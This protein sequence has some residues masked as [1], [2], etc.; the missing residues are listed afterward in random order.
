MMV[1][2]ARDILFSVNLSGFSSIPV[3]VSAQRPNSPDLSSP[4]T[5]EI[6]TAC[7]PPTIYV[8]RASCPRCPT[9][10]AREL[11]SWKEWANW[12]LAVAIARSRYGQRRALRSQRHRALRWHLHHQEI[13]Q[14]RPV[15]LSKLGGPLSF[16]AQARPM[17]GEALS[18]RRQQSPLAR[19]VDPASPGE[20]LRRR[21]LRQTE[22]KWFYQS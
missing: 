6:I 14:P 13:E 4:L 9:K 21:Q 2:W 10:E 18:A 15:A 12:Q 8:A 19:R 11:S 5:A 3:P 1:R 20:I 17:R 22:C 7:P 16:H